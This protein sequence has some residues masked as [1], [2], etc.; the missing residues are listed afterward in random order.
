MSN[1]LIPFESPEFGETN[2]FMDEDGVRQFV[3]RDVMRALEYSKESNPA[4]IFACVPERWKGVKP[5]HTLGGLQEMLIVSEPGLYFF[6]GRSNKPKAQP[7]QEW[8]AEKVVPSIVKKGIYSLPGAVP[9]DALLGDEGFLDRLAGKLAV[10]MPL[11]RAKGRGGALERTGRVPIGVRPDG[12]MSLGI[13]ALAIDRTGVRIMR[14]RRVELM[15][16]VG[17]LDDSISWR[18]GLPTEKAVEL[19]L[20]EEKKVPESE[21]KRFGREITSEGTLIQATEKGVAY[22]MEVYGALAGR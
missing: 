12:P 22:F 2:A 4:R 1:D 9:A 5:I 20:L 7:Y 11:A 15:Q 21:W 19:G 3:C 17:W 13:L 6:L 14:A 16:L 10:K 8:I 18:F